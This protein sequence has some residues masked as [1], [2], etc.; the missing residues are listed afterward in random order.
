M[1]S[2]TWAASLATV[3][4]ETEIWHR[5]GGENLRTHPSVC[6]RKVSVGTTWRKTIEADSAV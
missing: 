5:G 1:A 6:A 2:A 4:A 3:S